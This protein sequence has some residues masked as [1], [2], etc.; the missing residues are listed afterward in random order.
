MVYDCDIVAAE[1]SMHRDVC[2]LVL[3]LNFIKTYSG[4]NYHTVQKNI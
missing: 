1:N 4:S 3:I 2:A